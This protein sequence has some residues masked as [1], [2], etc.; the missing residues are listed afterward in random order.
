[1]KIRVSE[2]LEPPPLLGR[3][4]L[5]SHPVAMRLAGAGSGPISDHRG[6]APRLGEARGC[7]G[8]SQAPGGGSQGSTDAADAWQTSAISFKKYQLGTFQNQT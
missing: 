4:V 3:T 8:W 5:V 2:I 7:P 6:T 1:M